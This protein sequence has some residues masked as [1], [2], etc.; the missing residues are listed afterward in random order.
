MLSSDDVCV[1]WAHL[2]LT[3]LDL[4]V[5]VGERGSIAGLP[6]S[7]QALTTHTHTD[8][9]TQVLKQVGLAVVDVQ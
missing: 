3:N 1:A 6:L 4:A 2:R 5:H 9:Y 7:R 8:L